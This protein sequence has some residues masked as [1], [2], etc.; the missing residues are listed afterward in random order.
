MY[1]LGNL[2]PGYQLLEEMV[3]MIM[4]NY[5]MTKNPFIKECSKLAKTLNDFLLYRNK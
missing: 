3:I 1:Y 2:N 4:K 5:S